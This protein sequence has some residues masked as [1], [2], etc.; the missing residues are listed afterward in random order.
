M[1]LKSFVAKSLLI[2][3]LLFSATAL[4]QREIID[5]S[6]LTTGLETKPVYEQMPCSYRI[7]WIDWD[8][9]FRATDLKLGDRVIGINGKSFECPPEESETVTSETRTKLIQK[10]VQFGLGS[11]NE[12]Q[13]WKQQGLQEGSSLDLT[14]LRQVADGDQKLEIRGT[15]RHEHSY[16]AS[17]DKRTFGKNGP[18]ERDND[19]F[20]KVWSIWYEDFKFFLYRPF[21][22]GWANRMD[23]QRLLTELLEDKPRIDLLTTKYP[24]AFAKAVK[25]D[26]E[27]ARKVLQG[28]EF[29]LSAAD[30]EY[31]KLGEQRA[32]QIKTAAATAWKGMLKSLEA[33]TIPAFPTANPL[34]QRAKVVGKVVSLP[35]IEPRAWIDEAGHCFLT[36]GN[37]SQ[38]YYFVDC[39]NKAMYR[40]YEAQLRYQGSV[41]PKLEESH[42]MIARILDEPKMLMIGGQAQIGLMLEP[43]G[44]MVGDAMFVDL[45]TVK[46]NVSPFAGEDALT[47]ANLKL[48]PNN[49]SPRQVI[50]TMIQAIKWGDENLWKSLFAES[51][52]WVENGRVGYSPQR[53]TSSMEQDW[54]RSRRLI[55]ES[56]FDVRVAFVSEPRILITPQVIKSAPTVEEVRVDVRHVGQF[57][58]V[59]RSFVSINVHPVWLLQRINNGPWRIISAQEL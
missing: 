3:G 51:E 26:F 39:Q 33:Q 2:F 32:A 55:L 48:P 7:T 8:S 9:S 52:V 43:L 16:F 22:D 27:R 17:D 28:D 11:L 29:N 21:I 50:E 30:L 25:D 35:T 34:E 49:A 56:V 53:S 44:V 5:D 45:Q 20:S 47:S 6:Y 18:K 54:I 57:E 42:T 19:S 58:G 14:V 1:R 46:N 4:A 23:S 36:S 59:Y 13:I 38:G 24:G 10:F 37:S 40:L 12:T 15:L 31:R 41:N